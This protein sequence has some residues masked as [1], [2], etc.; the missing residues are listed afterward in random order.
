MPIIDGR[1]VDKNGYI[2]VYAENILHSCYDESEVR[3]VFM[4]RGHGDPF[5]ATCNACLNFV[6]KIF[7][8]F[9][10]D[11]HQDEDED[12]KEYQRLKNKFESK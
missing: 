12:W 2:D 11:Q 4:E 6:S 7:E 8:T 1:V 9:A 10:P 3:R 5:D